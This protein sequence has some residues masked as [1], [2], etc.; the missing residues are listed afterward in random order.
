MNK[1]RWIY[2]IG[3]VGDLSDDRYYEMVKMKFENRSKELK[4]LGYVVVNP[5]EICERDVDW[6]LA[7][8]RCINGLLQCDYISTLNDYK[9]SRGGVIE[10]DLACKLGYENILPSSINNCI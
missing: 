8:K 6:N 5:M 7:M 10:Y 2:I 4:A 3:K 1:R 9:E